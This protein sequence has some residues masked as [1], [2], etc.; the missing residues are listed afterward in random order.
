[1]PAN[2]NTNNKKQNNNRNDRDSDSDS[3]DSISVNNVIINNINNDNN[4]NNNENN[5]IWDM[6]SISS[7]ENSIINDNINNDNI[8]IINNYLDNIY[9]NM[10]HNFDNNL[11]NNNNLHN[12]LENNNNN[13]LD[14]NN[15]NNLDNINIDQ[16]E[17]NLQ[18]DERE[19]GDGVR[20]RWHGNMAHHNGIKPT[21]KQI[22]GYFN[23]T[24]N[25]NNDLECII[26]WGDRSGS[27]KAFW[28]RLTRA[29]NNSNYLK[30]IYKICQIRQYG[31]V[32]RYDIYC[33][34][35]V[36]NYLMEHMK[37]HC[38]K[39]N[40]MVKLHRPYHIRHPR[41]INNNT[42]NNNNLIQINHNDIVNINNNNNNNI[43]NNNIINNQ[44][45]HIV[46]NNNNNHNNHNNI[47]INNTLIIGTYNI[48]GIKRK[49]KCLQRLLEY[50]KLDV[51]AIQETLIKDTDWPLCISGYHS[52]EVSGSKNESERGLNIL[53]KKG[54]NGYSVGITSPWCMFIRLTGNGIYAPIIIASIYI[55]HV[56]KNGVKLRVKQQID[57]IIQR[58]PN[59]SIY[60]LGDWNMEVIELNGYLN[61]LI[62]DMERIKLY[63]QQ[64]TRRNPLGRSIDGLVCKSNQLIYPISLGTVK[65]RWDM[66]DHYPVLWE[67]DKGNNNNNNN[68]HNNININEF[69]VVNN[70]THNKYTR[71]NY[72]KLINPKMSIEE[73]NQKKNSFI[74]SNRFEVLLQ[75]I[76]EEY[77]INN[78]NEDIIKEADDFNT[79]CE[80]YEIRRNNILNNNNII[81]N[82]IN[83]EI[84]NNTTSSN[85]NTLIS[86]TNINENRLPTNSR[87][88]NNNI[89]NSTNIDNNHIYIK[90]KKLLLNKNSSSSSS[91][92][93]N[94]NIYNN[95]HHHNHTNYYDSEEENEI[96]LHVNN[97]MNHINQINK[98][99]KNMYTNKI[100]NN[101]ISNSR[102]DVS[103]NNNTR[104]CDEEYIRMLNEGIIHNNN[105][106]INNNNH[107]ISD[108]ENIINNNSIYVNKNSNKNNDINNNNNNN[109]NINNKDYIFE[110]QKI[111]IERVNKL[112]IH[113]DGVIGYLKNLNNLEDVNF[114]NIMNNNIS[115]TAK[116]VIN[117]MEFDR[118]VRELERRRPTK[119]LNR[120]SE[121][122]CDTIHEIYNDEVE[123]GNNNNNNNNNNNGGE[124]K[125]SKRLC[126]LIDKRCNAYKSTLV[127][128][129]T[130]NE[131]QQRWNNYRIIKARCKKYIR[132]DQTKV[133]HKSI[134]T[135]SINLRDE[136]Q[137]YWRWA[138]GL[139]KWKCKNEVVGIQP[140]IHPIT[141]NILLE[142][143]EILNAWSYHYS[144]LAQDVTK[145]SRNELYW[146]NKFQNIQTKIFD[147][148]ITLNYNI[149]NDEIITALKIMKNNKAPGGDG[150]PSE[151]LKLI[152]PNNNNNDNNNNN[153]NNMSLMFRVLKS[154]IDYQWLYGIIPNMWQQSI[155]VSIPK[156]GDLSDM[157][158]YRGISL[159]STT[160]KLLINIIRI[161]LTTVC[162]NN[163]VFIPA[164]AGFRKLEECALQ[165][166]TLYEICKRRLIKGSG[167]ILA[168]IDIKKAYDTVPHGALFHKLWK[169][170]I[171][172]KLFLYIKQL[173][174]ESYIRI[175]GSGNSK[176]RLSNEVQLKRGLRQGCP[177]SPLLFNLFI[178]DILNDMDG[179][180]VRV[181]GLDNQRIQGL[182]FADD[183]V[184]MAPNADVMINML[185]KLSIWFTNN[186]M[187]AG[188]NKCGIMCIGDNQEILIPYQER[189][190]INNEIIP[191]VNQYKYLG[192]IITNTLDV[193]DMMADRFKYGQKLVNIMSPFLKSQCIPIN[194][195]TIVM[196]AV[197]IPT[198]IYGS[199]IYG[200]NK[201][202]TS[203]MQKYLNVAIKAIAGV[204]IKAAVSNVALWRELN[205]TPICALAAARRAR[206]YRKCGL[207][208]TWIST[209]LNGIFK[210]QKWTW[211]LGTPR[212]LKRYVD[213]L[214]ALEVRPHQQVAVGAWQNMTPED[215]A[216]YVTRVVWEREEK[217]HRC[218]TAT[219]YIDYGYE[220][221][222]IFKIG[223]KH[224]PSLNI[225]FNTIIKC[226]IGGFWTGKRLASR[227][228]LADRYNNFC[229]CCQEQ[230]AESLYHLI[231][232][233]SRWEIS[234]EQWLGPLL[235]DPAI[236]AMVAPQ[237]NPEGLVAILLGGEFEGNRLM[238]WNIPRNQVDNAI[239]HIN[240]QNNNLHQ[241]VDG[242]QI[243][244]TDDEL[245]ED[246]EDNNYDLNSVNS[247][248]T[249]EFQ[250]VGGDQEIC[251]SF[252]IA[253]YFTS[254][255]RTRVSIIRN[256]R[257][258]A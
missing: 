2:T 103:F 20:I 24:N 130:V 16:L 140:I 157:N 1:M 76:A 3:N 164:Q 155:I 110:L 23:T 242:E 256:C 56:N 215:I 9:N 65:I 257:R 198:L 160:L 50:E 167:T 27:R 237:L 214:A 202:I 61:N 254:V 52:F 173:Y 234:R 236:Q 72:K 192:L 69:Q 116:I 148:E 120:L 179:M 122:W 95:N 10:Q 231:W 213:R 190:K 12:N 31:E 7:N 204:S 113:E 107:N 129:L 166:A 75:E 194:M 86:Q 53:I 165:V 118:E 239:D 134:M 170:G 80:R 48:N 253:A 244:E 77:T 101:N 222:Q 93:K 58:Y 137:K 89:N 78:D 68:N 42:I 133:W 177:L 146:Y 200:M 171:K 126:K 195:R 71:L 99:D 66:S 235:G 39:W 248:G 141:G 45:N 36:E 4:D 181:P 149:T 138:S 111:N 230:R 169:I 87:N 216:I 8:N 212:W 209:L 187:E 250:F 196:K 15:N 100:T 162:E 85:H 105:V 117:D 67:M 208:N 6:E 163:S 201:L 168:F 161:R 143:G 63:G 35:G 229:P 223:N 74:N 81:N 44:N 88:Q 14:N 219:R 25:N 90:N 199:E 112:I 13:N 60:L 221:N 238:N 33:V 34:K 41:R 251:A 114:N 79:L 109:I 123:V 125:L 174:E 232:E 64:R 18:I 228:L 17:N 193:K 184:L 145:H 38:K 191:I 139:G 136:P 135:A 225:G 55:S 32:Y 233:C 97:N 158:N 203:N 131:L 121:L 115:K 46:N 51:L 147:C 83:N 94:N 224:H 182:L 189:F 243:D 245:E 30:L 73:K 186:E 40:W 106:I 247:N 104:Y 172:G 153:N 132:L 207:S 128:G 127:R 178:N 206:A 124:Y 70:H 144:L 37:K 220:N 21:L 246:N 226:R 142:H 26:C 62:N 84:S 59:D 96:G 176:D 205:C 19:I 258:M 5:V 102:D 255:V 249:R 151:I 217:C 92:N 47:N 185:D 210:S 28:A 197:V 82:N 156:K 57:D 98:N 180:G 29:C 241:N 150:I 218:R 175:R 22:K 49:R 227:G 211:L 183:L 54:Y 252:R 240:Y 152:I 91:N 108:D 119:V 11:D 154:L 188:I 43:N 159:M